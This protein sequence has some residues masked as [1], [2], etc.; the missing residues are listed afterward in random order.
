MK[1]H[2][3]ARELEVHPKELQN[4][5]QQNRLLARNPAADLT[6]RAIEAARGQFGSA[7]TA[8]ATRPAPG[9]E[10]KVVLPPSL[11][12][13]DLAEKLDVPAVDVQKKLI[14]NG[15]MATINQVIDYGTAEIVADEF[16][17]EAEPV[18]SE[19]LVATEAEGESVVAKTREE[20][21]SLAHEDPSKLRPR[22]PIVT[23]LG[24][25]DHGKTSILDAIRN[26]R[27]G[28]RGGGGGHPPPGAP[29]APRRPRAA[30]RP[31]PARGA[32]GRP[33]PGDRPGRPRRRR[34]HRRR[35]EH[36]GG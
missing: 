10:R 23:V 31:G 22:P 19:D 13:K 27:V 18:A 16:G 6:P 4:F 34:A 15:V 11:T 33:P 28:G 24:H 3:L 7:R 26:T 2:E 20:L 30:R 5:L 1:V 32:R 17:F 36:G 8:V 12:V 29:P 25:V 21:F 35:R 9:G 14:A